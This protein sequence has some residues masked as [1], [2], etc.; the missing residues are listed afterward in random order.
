MS[1]IVFVSYNITHARREAGPIIPTRGLLQ[2]DSLSPYLFILCVEGLLALIRKNESQNIVQGVKVCSQAPSITH[3]FFTDDSYL[4]YRANEDEGRG[5]LRMLERY[6][7]A[8]GQNVNRVK[9]SVF[10]SSN[11]GEERRHHL[12]QIL[13]MTEA[14]GECTYLGLPNMMGRR[15]PVTLGF[16][17]ERV[18]K[19]IE[20]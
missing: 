6:K 10:F 5:F 18:K 11:I 17:K 8:L 15:E 1:C 20:N 3:M 4:Y 19:R 9:S 13:Q 12:C 7:I 14:G 2:G 16:L